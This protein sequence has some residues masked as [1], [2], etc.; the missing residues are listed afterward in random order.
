MCKGKR[1]QHFCQ[2]D[3]E[4]E[5]T[6]YFSRRKTNYYKQQKKVKNKDF[7]GRPKSRK[8]QR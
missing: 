3:M 4:S 6:V 8:E 2:L 5:M 7:F 1:Q